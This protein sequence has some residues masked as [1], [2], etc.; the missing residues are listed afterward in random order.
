MYT[1]DD[2]IPA[3]YAG[4]QQ[5]LQ[6]NVT[7]TSELIARAADEM[8][9]ANRP[10]VERVPLRDLERVK[11][12]AAEYLRD[13]AA[14]G[15]LPTVRGIAA[16]LGLARIALYEYARYHPGSDFSK[17]LEDFSDL[18]GELTMAAANDG[19]I[20][21][22]PAIF[23]A[24]ARFGFREQPTQ[25]EIVQSNSPLG[26]VMDAEEIAERYAELPDE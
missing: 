12:V 5:T 23:T 25:L 19:T 16:R 15:F 17:W 8:Q 26:P 1:K 22:V 3:K 24:K 7:R 20:A 11:V 9:M 18:C 6:A 10:E 4:K 2:M 13:C 21:A 14:N